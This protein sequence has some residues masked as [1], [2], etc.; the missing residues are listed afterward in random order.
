MRKTNRFHH[1]TGATALVVAGIGVPASACQSA[2]THA[3]LCAATLCAPDGAI[4][5]APRAGGL[6]VDVSIVDFAFSPSQV[7]IPTGS[8]VRWTHFG[9]FPHT[10]TSSAVP[11]V[12]DSGAMGSGDDFSHTF[13]GVGAFDYE[14]IF[15]FGMDG[16]VTVRLPGDA[17]GDNA[18]NIADFSILGTHYNQG[19]ATYND[20]DFNLNGTVEIGDFAI[21][22]ANYNTAA[23]ARGAAVPEPATGMIAAGLCFITARR[24][25]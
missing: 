14:C 19:G 24:R 2:A 12:F 23:A 6:T 11:P 20:G 16:R 25:R 15:H 4:N 7:I 8:Q 3:A 13:A 17:N 10:A 9:L 1:I 5:P 21:L 22:A 18:V